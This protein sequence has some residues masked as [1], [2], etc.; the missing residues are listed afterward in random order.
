MTELLFV[1]VVTPLSWWVYVL[2]A[3]G[4]THVTIVSVT[5]FLHRCQAHRSVI[6]HP[7]V[8]HVMRF[9]L[10]VTTGMNTKE[11]T[12]IHRKHHAKVE[13]DEDPHSPQI[14]GIWRVLF[15]GAL[16]YRTESM[17]RET[18]DKYGF[19]TPDDTLER[20]IYTPYKNT[21]IIV[22]LVADLALFGIVPGVLIWLVQMIWIPFWAAGVVNGIG[23]YFGYR[24]YQCKDESRNIVPLGLIIGGEEL[25]NNHHAF[26]TSSKLSMRWYEIDLG[27]MYLSLFE[28]FGLAK[29]K[30]V[31]PKLLFQVKQQSD[32]DTLQSVIT[33]RFEVLARFTDLMSRTCAQENLPFAKSKHTIRIKVSSFR[34]WLSQRT[35][36][37][38]SDEIDAI[39]FM[40]NNSAGVSRISAMQGELISLWED[41]DA[42]AE[43]LLIRMREWCRKAENS[44]IDALSRFARELRGFSSKPYQTVAGVA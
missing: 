25:H 5:V 22:M 37:L 3:I 44:G 42:T 14:Y 30:R 28:R 40:V 31:A 1:G 7:A 21:G 17:N 24:N 36:L 9:W 19:G 33:H 26:P 6:L 20:K 18:I 38:S 13:T 29:I 34:K 41:R 2:I 11:W 43:Q 8:S 35:N 10:W 32:L 39:K 23:H 12:A 4:M 27:W 15:G 16:L